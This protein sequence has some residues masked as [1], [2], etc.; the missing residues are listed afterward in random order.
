VAKMSFKNENKVFEIKVLSKQDIENIDLKS[1]AI[2]SWRRNEVDKNKFNYIVKK[3]FL[4][5]EGYKDACST[6]PS[7]RVIRLSEGV[8]TQ[9][10]YF[11]DGSEMTA[12]YDPRTAKTEGFF[13][14]AANSV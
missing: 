7:Y 1:E 9:Q 5:L 11:A 8:Y 10:L 12:E 6:D 14:I 13:Y 4:D 2:M 3:E